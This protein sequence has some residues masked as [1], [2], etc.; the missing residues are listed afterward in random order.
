[1]IKFNE[2]FQVNNYLKVIKMTI[3]DNCLFVTKM[4][5]LYINVTLI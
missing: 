4:K 2:Y 5:G 3:K 1:M